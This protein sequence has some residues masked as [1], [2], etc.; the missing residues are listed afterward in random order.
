MNT[1][2]P[3]DSV[4]RGPDILAAIK[5]SGVEFIVS[6]PDIVTSEGLLRPVAADP[7]VKHIRLCKEDEGVSICAA[8][9]YCDRRALLMMQQTGMY[10]SVNAIRAIAVG[11][12]L[13]VCMLVGLQGAEPDVPPRESALHIVRV[14]QPVLD[15]LEIEHHLLTTAADV[16]KIKPAIESAYERSRPV[17]L[18][19][20]ARLP[21]A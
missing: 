12:E 7:D 18:L 5:A 3:N 1:P 2:T 11:Y 19:I 15:A 8:L 16:E 14:A 13:P 20:G 10:D 6:V 21:P 9:S 4:L 17:V